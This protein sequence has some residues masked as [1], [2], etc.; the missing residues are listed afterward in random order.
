MGSVDELAKAADANALPSLVFGAE[1]GTG[2]RMYV[3][4]VARR[5]S[6]RRRQR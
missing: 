5:L 4:E 6:F 2:T 1:Y 3:V